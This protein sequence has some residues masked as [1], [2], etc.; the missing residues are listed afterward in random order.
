MRGVSLIEA[1]LA[2]ALSVLVFQGFIK[3]Y[4][5][6]KMT[7]ARQAAIIQLQQD[8]ILVTSVLT[9]A[10]HETKGLGCT[11]M[12]LG[13]IQ[14]ESSGIQ[15]KEIYPVSFKLEDSTHIKLQ[16]IP[17]SETLII[18]DCK[19][20]LEIPIPNAHEMTVALNAPLM[21]TDKTEIGLSRHEHI[22][23]SPSGRG[24]YLQQAHDKPTLF[25]PSVEKIVFL[26]HSNYLEIDGLLVSKMPVNAR[27]MQYFWI[28][29]T[30]TP[31]DRR[32]YLPVHLIL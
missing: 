20:A 18:T 5:T 12:P 19:Q 16:Q 7:L 32:Y 1:L 10:L 29:Q 2:V 15:L 28:N 27:P 24:L 14:L 6:L 31:P 22:Y 25:V 17:L 4:D 13:R 3:L 21:V 23:L 30:I 11:K 9:Q 26:P 8:A